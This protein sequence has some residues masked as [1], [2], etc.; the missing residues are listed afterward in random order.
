MINSLPDTTAQQKPEGGPPLHQYPPRLALW[1]LTIVL[2]LTYLVG[3]IIVIIP[4]ALWAGLAERIESPDAY[5]DSPIFIWGGIASLWIAALAT[6]VIAVGWPRL[7]NALSA[8]HAVPHNAWLRW[9]G[10]PF[11]FLL[12]IPFITITYSF[13]VS[14]TAA[15]LSVLFDF[16]MSG[17]KA[18]EVLFSS[19]LFQVATFPGITVAVPIAEE[20]IFR[21][22]L[23]NA[24][25]FGAADGPNRW[26]RHIFPVFLTSAAFIGVHVLAGFDTPGPLIVII[27]LSFYL[28]S[29]RALSGSV[30]T[31]I[32]AHM[33]WNGLAAC[34]SILIQYLPQT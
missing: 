27:L 24:L 12:A 7:W 29:L 3:Q 34:L 5:L 19:V 2:G 13:A 15:I 22:A 1:G 18:Q 32:V 30:K 20:F 10:P 26:V 33:T 28:G 25:L 16:T 31:S 6:I 11:I 17:V 8:G 14:F 21:G 4:F 23:Y 9:D